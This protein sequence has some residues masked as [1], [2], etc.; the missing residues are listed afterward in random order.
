M[1]IYNFKWFFYVFKY[2]LPLES[3]Q[4]QLHLQPVRGFGLSS[5]LSIQKGETDWG[6]IKYQ[7]WFTYLSI[8]KCWTKTIDATRRNIQ[9]KKKNSQYIHLFNNFIR[10]INNFI[11]RNS[12]YIHLFIY[13]INLIHSL[14]QLTTDRSADG[15]LP[16]QLPVSEIYWPV[17]WE[18]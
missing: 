4:L 5:H 7:R 18:H 1:L 10:R 12:Q 16:G 15:Q 13:F 6:M 2:E 3:F 9:K 11:R 8:C 14:T 17:S